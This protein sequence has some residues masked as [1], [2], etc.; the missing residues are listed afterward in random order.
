MS[1]MRSHLRVSRK[2][3]TF[4]LFFKAFSDCF[5]KNRRAED[6]TLKR[7]CMYRLIGGEGTSKGASEKVTNE[8]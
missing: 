7:C 3:E 1:V 2:G 8:I 4:D 5:V 6:E